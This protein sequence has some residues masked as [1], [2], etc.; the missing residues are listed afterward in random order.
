MS[1]STTTDIDRQAARQRALRAIGAQLAGRL[2]HLVADAARVGLEGPR[3]NA[4]E[5]ARHI[6]DDAFGSTPFEPRRRT[7]DAA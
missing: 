4:L 7:D 3:A 6:L 2:A 5:A 1:T